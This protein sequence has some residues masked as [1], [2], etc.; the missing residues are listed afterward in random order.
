MRYLFKIPISFVAC[1]PLLSGA[2]LTL[3]EAL[4]LAEQNHP[5]LRAGAAQIDVA[6]AG[7]VTA[8]AYPNPEAGFRAGG[9]DYRVPGNVRGFVS[10]YQFSQPLELGPLRPARLEVELHDPVWERGYAPIAAAVVA[11]SSRFN[12]L[13]YLTI[14]RYL[15]LVFG[16]LVLLLLGMVLWR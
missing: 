16:A 4:E 9:Q 2:S 15:S 3:F 5:Q 11:L 6:R 7:L 10:T 14:R 1:I 12:Y 13:Q 8:K